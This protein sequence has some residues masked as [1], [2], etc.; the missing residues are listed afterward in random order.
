MK[1]EIISWWLLIVISEQE[2]F[3]AIHV[4]KSKQANRK[5]NRH[6]HS[7]KESDVYLHDNGRISEMHLILRTTVQIYI[8]F[9]CY[10]LSL[11]VTLAA[12]ATEKREFTAISK[13]L[14]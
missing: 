4:E 9:L 8:L 11:T 5:E 2:S 10:T 3:V 6:L 1:L 7:V 12:E 14:E 13:S